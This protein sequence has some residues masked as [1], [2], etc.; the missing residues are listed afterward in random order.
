MSDN[1]FVK[2]EHVEFVVTTLSFVLKNSST[3]PIF[4]VI[5]ADSVVTSRRFFT[6]CGWPIE[7]CA[8]SGILNFPGGYRICRWDRKYQEGLLPAVLPSTAG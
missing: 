7:Q 3:S 6:K 2:N 8:L 4:A 1:N 5:Y